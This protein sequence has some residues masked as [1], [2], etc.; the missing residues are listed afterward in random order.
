ML[1]KIRYQ[2]AED[3]KSFFEK[4]DE[5]KYNKNDDIFEFSVDYEKFNGLLKS[6]AGLKKKWTVCTWGDR[7]DNSKENKESS[8]VIWLTEKFKILFEL[9]DIDIDTNI[10]EQIL[11]QTKEAFFKDL[12]KYFNLTLQMRNSIPN[13]TAPEDDYLISP[14]RNA[15][16]GFY[17]SRK[18]DETLPKDADAN[19][20]YN[21]ARKGLW[22]IDQIK[23]AEDI[24]NVKLAISNK[25]WL[26]YA[27]KNE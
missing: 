15:T 22:A 27:Q 1:K 11:K 14:V 8:K 6:D 4:I 25:E 2:N 16:G 13:S 26:E 10:K 18:A 9:Y 20:A 19:G 17:D 5:I 21:I 23:N 24:T 3:Y 7:I 12:I